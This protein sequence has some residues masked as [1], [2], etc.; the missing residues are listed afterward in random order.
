MTA[1]LSSGGVAAEGSA[2]PL[3]VLDVP[4]L[5]QT[6]ALCG[7][8]AAAMVMRYWG[9]ATTR[10]EAFA[11]LVDSSRGGITTGALVGRLRTLGFQALPF[12]GEATLVQDHLERGRPV[13]ALIEAS[14]ARFHYVVV[15]AWRGDRVL[16]HDPA[17][18]PFRAEDAATLRRQW[19]G[20]D[21]WALLALPGDARGGEAEPPD[22]R[23]STA[24]PPP[25]GCDRLVDEAV[26]RARQ[27]AFLAAEQRLGAAVAL[28]PERGRPLREL[29]AVRF[30]QE[31]W[32]EAAILGERA[33]RLA[34]GDG[35]AW[36]LLGTSRFL[37]DDP[38]GA[39]RAWN[40][41]G[42]PVVDD[43]AFTGLERTRHDVALAWLDVPASVPLT[44][45]G[46]TR[47]RRRLAEMP[48][49][50]LTRLSYRPTGGGRARVEAA[51]VERPLV[52]RPWRLLVQAAADALTER[53]TRL[54]LDSPVRRGG[55]LELAVRWWE[56]RPAAALAATVPRG[57]GLP[58]LV[59]VQGAWEEQS[60]ATTAD[61]GP[62]VETTRR[63]AVTHGDWL[64]PSLRLGL[65][66]AGERW[67]GRGSF[68]SL[69]GRLE[70]RLLADRA[71]LVLDGRGALPLSSQ[72]GFAAGGVTVAL[73]SSASPRRVVARGQ[74]GF[75]GA[76]ATA[77]LGRWPGAGVGH[78]REPLLRAHPLL[79]DGVVTGP[80]FGRRLLHASTEVEVHLATLG[81][82]RLG[83][84]GFVDWARAR[85]RV[86]TLEDG[87]ALVDVGGGLRLRL[88]GNLATLRVDAATGLREGGFTLS[89]GWLLPW[90]R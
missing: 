83:A 11:D 64:T 66:L 25:D 61:T 60:Y 58:G 17:L 40:R 1:L 38:E 70:Q 10:P 62:L 68:L 51:V 26:A 75:Y 5:A 76:S 19:S 3:H 53:R 55:S 89:A 87:S 90:P 46:L 42:E 49:A 36:R 28:C 52:A 16:L 56:R 65:E 7:G 63:G 32:H 37:D 14:P 34:P 74:I 80:A 41:V 30:R 24:T 4:F 33:T 6:E 77:P 13:I 2:A 85:E 22:R 82:L 84:A 35:H 78:A 15:V 88:P 27:D 20:S 43:V 44:A 23:S 86:S 59:A 50:A 12:R 81:P 54:R 9:A 72:S 48:A 18:G 57:L 8:A 45:P 29:A 21:H 47:A 79:E 31:R 69:G 73:R 39:L 67:S 71:A